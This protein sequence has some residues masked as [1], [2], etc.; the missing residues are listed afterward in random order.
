MPSYLPSEYTPDLFNSLPLF[1]D[2]RLLTKERVKKEDLSKL[3][4]LFQKYSVQSTFGLIMLHR[5]FL[6]DQDEKL[7]EY[8]GVSTPW[9]VGT[10]SSS[11]I[12][13]GCIVPRCWAFFSDGQLHP[14]EFRFAVP[15]EKIQEPEFPAEFVGEFYEFV[16]IRGLAGLLGLTVFG[17]VVT[18]DGMREV[19][20]TIGRVSIT[21][22]I[23]GEE[24]NGT[25]TAWT[26][27]CHERMDDSE[28]MN[29]R[30]CWVC[31]GCE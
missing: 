7:I 15:G 18:V 26:F 11:T 2:A 21:F 29:A 31:Q 24:A 25:E 27:G 14:T 20:R 30:I 6:L 16:S 13:G 17:T 12:F 8:R 3:R 9:K 1:E 23:D 19:E 28:L 22:P 4:E 10:T 5:H